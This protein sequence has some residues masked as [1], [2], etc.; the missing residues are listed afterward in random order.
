MFFGEYEHS[1]DDKSRL[2]LPARFR[3]AFA[4][5]VVLTRGLDACLDVFART[6]WYARVEERLA[7]LDPLTKEARQLMR[8]LFAAGTDAALDKQGR[9]LVPPALVTYASLGREVVVAGVRDHL[10]IWNRT[11][12]AAQ[13]TTFEGSADDVAERLADKRV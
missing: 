3:D 2:T 5:G 4:D 6:D 11:S 13:V 10:E 9:V 1:I 7:P 8:H 12:W